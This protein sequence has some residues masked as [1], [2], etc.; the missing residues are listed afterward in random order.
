MNHRVI[1]RFAAGAALALIAAA[2]QAQVFST[3]PGLPVPPTGTGP[4]TMSAT[5]DVSGGPASITDLNLIIDIT[6]T[7]CGDLDIILVPPS[8]DRYIH[9]TSDS[10]AGGDNFTFTRFDQQSS[11]NISSGVFP[12]VA[13]F[14]GTF[15]PEGGDIVWAGTIPLPGFSLAGLDDFIGTDSNGT[16]TLIIHDDAGG[17]LGTLNYLS[18]ELNG[19]TDPNGPS[20]GTPP[21]AIGAADP[22]TVPNDGS[23]VVTFSVTVTP[24]T[25][26]DS[27][28]ASTGSVTVDASGVGLGGITL[29]DNGVAPDQVAGDFVFTGDA[30]IPADTAGAQYIMPYTVIDDQDR[31][32]NGNINITV[33][34]PPPPC[35][36]GAATLSFI[37]V[38]SDGPVGDPDNSLVSGDFGLVENINQ[39]S[40]TGRFTASGGS[41]RSEARILIV[42]PSGNTYDVGQFPGAPTSGGVWDITDLNVLVGLE[43]GTGTWT[44]EFWESF[45]DGVVPDA[46]YDGV[47][48]SAGLVATNPTGTG[49]ADPALVI[50]DGTGF[51]DFFVTVSPGAEPL[52]TNITVSAD[53][54]PIGLGTIDL[55]DTGVFPDQVAGDNIFSA[56][57]DIPNGAAP[58][59]AI[60]PFTIAD[61]QGRFGGGAIDVTITT[62]APGCP[63]GQATLSF[64]DVSSDAALYSGTNSV[65][66]GDFGIAGQINTFNISGRVIQNT[67]FPYN[68][69]ARIAA[70]APSGN[71]YLI[72]PFTNNLESPRDLIDFVINFPGI[73]DG[74]GTWTF[75]FYESF[76]DGVSP[77]ATWQQICFGADLAPTN[78]TATATISPNPVS[79]DGLQPVTIAVTVVPGQVPV[80][81]GIVVSVDDSAIGG[82]GSLA[83]LDAGNFP[84]DVAGDNIFTASTTV[85]YT[86]AVGANTLVYSVVDAEGRSAGGNLNLNVTDAIGA[87][88]T[89]SGC[90]VA[91]IADC[92]DVQGG[93]FAG[94][95]TACFSPLPMTTEGAGEFEDISATGV[96]AGLE[97]IDD[98]TVNIA[99]PFTFNFFGTDY[100]DGYISSN[101]NFQFGTNNS[102]AYVNGAIPSAGV[103][104]NALYVLWDDHD[105]DV[106]GTIFTET[107]GTPGVDQRF[108]IQWNNLGQYN[109][110]NTPGDT[111][112]FQI[113]LFEDNSFE[114]RYLFVS[115]EWIAG[116]TT[117]IGFEDINGVT[118]VTLDE[119]RDSLGAAAPISF[120]GNSQGQDTGVCGGGSGCPVC[121]ADFDQNGGVDGADI[122]AFFAEFE[123]GATCAD[124]DQNGGV[125]GGDIGAFFVLFEAGGC[126]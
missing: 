120:R 119:T 81:T 16:W 36:P 51:T 113:V 23:G 124:V 97:G 65:V 45:N 31:F 104:N 9:L 73:E 62:P 18:L 34:A 98:G 43:A 95:G 115:P 60:V 109:V 37:G 54:S 94:N 69:E 99:L 49:Y 68:A 22:A 100:T 72:Q 118:A 66:T 28:F 82:T 110:G 2:G 29:L 24:G 48:F 61:A 55:L 57:V 40:I 35:A 32:T 21:T 64:T 11:V 112:T 116:D 53:G 71:V 105:M 4:G 78:P 56:R 86:T 77:D 74:T 10:G 114:Y 92:I 125:D 5:L 19:A 33:T 52:S 79:R 117:T 6:H 80:S 13:P 87:C 102:A 107:R 59:A 83:L 67:A 111:N 50:N 8:N 39:V 84:D 20:F 126:D 15:Q 26:P 89:S 3:N 47:C 108:I 30:T 63:A 123:S 58:G 1:S 12:A 70:T 17:D 85:S 103:P 76:N 96:S 91:N 44:F 27:T 101:A 7:Y 41:Y 14:N 88:C 122:G 25:F 90:V 38:Q 46:V 106:S 93:T 121:A 42:A 75:E